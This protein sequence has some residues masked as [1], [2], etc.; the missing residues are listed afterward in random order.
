MPEKNQRKKSLL[1]RQFTFG[2]NEEKDFFLENLA[3]LVGAGITIPQALSAIKIEVKS[4]RMREVIEKLLLDIDA[5]STLWKAVDKVN[6]FGS[7]VISLIKLGELTGKLSENQKV[8]A[9]QQQ[10]QREFRARIQSAMAY[11]LF[12]FSL[13]FIVG[14]VVTWFVLPRLAQVFSSL[15]IKLPLIT[16]VLISFGTFM[17]NYGFIFVPFT[18]TALSL[19]IYFIFAYKKTKFI[20]QF[21][22]LNIPVIGKLTKEVELSRFGYTLGT[23][24]SA[25]LPMLE[26]LDSL[27]DSSGLFAYKKLYRHF[28]STIEEGLSFQKSFAKYASTGS[29]VSMPV[30][31]MI[32]AGEKSG[33]LPETLHKIGEIYETKTDTTSKNL[34]VLLE[35][36]LLVIVWFGV[37]GVAVSVILPIYSMLGSFSE[38]QDRTRSSSGR[39]V[40]EAAPAPTLP[41][42]IP[43]SLVPE[44]KYLGRVELISEGFSA[45]PVLDRA[46]F[47]G[48]EI[49]QVLPG[50]IY[51]Y[52]EISDNWYRLILSED[53]D[54]VA[55]TGWVFGDYVRKR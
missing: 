45:F 48:S 51:N 21:L 24:L 44:R 14:L 53:E 11:P 40:E 23:L 54:G 34:S 1:M 25:G 47:E 49:G 13:T 41:P 15:R 19:A 5:G 12:V 20:G 43:E 7:Q 6:I 35:P 8:L 22:L 28:R 27:E 4:E 18:V 33:N 26:A 10:K 37:F 17:G 2:F 9:I 38:S 32:I 36:I 30:Q 42:E 31:Q 16:K 50:E 55:V 52:E 39:V 3:M 46:S 29:L